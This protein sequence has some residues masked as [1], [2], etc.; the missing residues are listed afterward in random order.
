MKLIKFSVRNYRSILEAYKLSL[1]SYTV[2]VGPNNE[3]K[4]NIVRA[5]AL[6]LAVLTRSRVYRRTRRSPARYLRTGFRFDYEWTRDFPISL[7]QR[8]PTGRSECN[9]E[10]ELT[11]V[12]FTNFR[13]QVGVN[14]S[15][16]LNVKL[17][18]GPEDVSIEILMKGPGKKVLNDRRDKVTEFIKTH[19]ASEYISALR[20]PEMALEIIDNLLQQE[21]A[22]LE[23]DCNYQRLLGNLQELQR[24]VLENIATKLKTTICEFIPGVKNIYL[25]NEQLSQAFRSSANIIIDDGAQTDLSSKGDGIIS[26][27]TISLIKHVSEAGLGDKSLILSIEEP[28]SHLHPE[29]IHGL[30]QVLK[31]IS[32]KQQVIIT[33]HSP[34]MV[35]REHINQNIIV[36]NARASKAKRIEDIRGALGIQMADNLIGAYLVLIVEGEEDRD[37]LLSFLSAKSTTIKN[38]INRRFLT[39]DHLAGASNLQYKVTYYKQNVYNIHVFVDNDEA[40]RKAIDEALAKNLIE[41]TEYNLASC[42]GMQN[43]ELED[44]LVINCYAGAIQDKF[45]VNL[46]QPRFRS[47][48]NK[49][50]DRAE[51]LFRLSGKLWNK[52]VKMQVKRAVVDACIKPGVNALN[53]HHTGPI[54]ALISSLEAKLARVG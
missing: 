34:I 36:Q 32:N 13:E 29:A 30:R 25:S 20:P 2:L 26:L 53:P 12:D 21:L 16:N 24:P 33:T 9:L 50:A 37:L 4:S 51:Q 49:W 46:D 41:D 45:D 44:L 38:A 23:N 22:T 19:I 48:K 40:G 27:T 10:L 15:T 43:S 1:G 3:G 35:E 42:Q 5:L 54:D 31:D 52:S 39:I 7:Q 18:F 47:N 17:G 14:L 11:T 28:E 8:N 6:S